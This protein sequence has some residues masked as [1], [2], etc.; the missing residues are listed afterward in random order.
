[1]AIGTIGTFIYCQK[2]NVET[3]LKFCLSRRGV[4]QG[5]V[6]SPLLFNA[7]F[8]KMLIKPLEGEATSLKVNRIPI[9]NIR[10]ADDNVILA[11]A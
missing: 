7:Y 5:Y 10:Y 9:K 11:V 8:E 6:L 1:M 2:F 4:R 3:T